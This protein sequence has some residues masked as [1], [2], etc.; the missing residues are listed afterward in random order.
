M[1]HP[2]E[3]ESGKCCL[4]HVLSTLLQSYARTIPF[5]SNTAREDYARPDI[6]VIKA[7]AAGIE[8]TT[9]GTTTTTDLMAIDFTAHVPTGREDCR[10]VQEEDVPPGISVEMDGA[11]GI[12]EVGEIMD[13]TTDG[14]ITMGDGEDLTPEADAHKCLDQWWATITS[15]IRT[16]NA[17]LEDSAAKL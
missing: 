13:G 11:A 3:D 6:S 1:T 14:T 16:M 9:F 10:D 7:G 5:R 17:H 15:A 2:N 4:H 12:T 8:A